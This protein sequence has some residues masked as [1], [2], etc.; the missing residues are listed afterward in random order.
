MYSVLIIDDEANVR[1]VLSRFFIKRGWPVHTAG[2]GREGLEICRTHP[3]DVVITD[4]VMPEME[5][6]ETIKA[7]RKELPAIKIIAISGGGRIEPGSYLDL[8]RK[9]GAH[10]VFEKPFDLKNMRATIEELLNGVESAM[11]G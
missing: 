5:G 6:L 10:R 1:D 7:I 11:A 3:V 2:D 8:A 9:L 4:I